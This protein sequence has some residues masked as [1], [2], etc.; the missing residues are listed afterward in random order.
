MLRPKD[1]AG[2]SMSRTIF[3][4]QRIGVSRGPDDGRRHFYKTNS[5]K[6]IALNQWITG[7]Q[8]FPSLPARLRRV[9]ARKQ[10]AFP[11]TR[12]ILGAID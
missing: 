1:V 5:P 2:W 10:A 3:L 8:K 4:N 7:T 6:K 9:L 11:G 12:V